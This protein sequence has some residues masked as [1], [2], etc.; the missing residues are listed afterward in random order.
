MNALQ[1][2]FRDKASELLQSSPTITVAM[3]RGQ[4]F[5]IETC[6]VVGD[7]DELHCIVKPS[8]AIVE[9]VRDDAHVAFTVNQGF[10]NQMLQGV[11]RAFFLGGLD[12][13]PQLRAQLLAKTPD[14]TAFLTTIRNLG[15][16]KIL[17]D[18]IAVTDDTNVGL[19]PRQVYVPESASAL[20]DRRRRWKQALGMTSW[21]LVLIPVLTAALLARHAG[22]SVSWWLLV[23]VC[24]VALLVHTGTSLLAT[25]VGFRRRRA[26]SE[27]LGA[28]RLLSAGLLSTHQVFEIGILCLAFGVLLGLVLVGLRG[29]PLL[30]LGLIGLL[31]ALL[32]AGWPLYLSSRVLEDAV[33]F[34]GL[35]PLVVLVTFAT[36]TGSLHMGPLLVA[37]PLGCLAESILHASHLQRFAADVDAKFRTLAVVLGW[38]RARLMFYVFA[39]LPYVLV[40]L[41][42]FARLLPGWVWL[43]CLSVPLAGRGALAVYRS[44]VEQTASLA[45]L[46]RQMALAYVA[47]GVLLLAGLLLG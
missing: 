13:Y 8:P 43:T 7:S 40:A 44:T 31:G 25:F 5:T 32:Y 2:R 17:P 33:V 22:L 3:G 30:V 39:S 47:F 37:L 21:P 14:A 42:M 18:W 11:G 23:A 26:R 15:V 34:V 24:I 38:E 27:A 9:A 35:G 46:D 4:T 20:P 41:L 12:L 19:G 28:S 36:L 1:A 45:G 6:Y 16:V 10:P 29:A